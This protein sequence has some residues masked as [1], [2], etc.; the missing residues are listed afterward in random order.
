MQN[1]IE[2]IGNLCTELRPPVV[3]MTDSYGNFHKSEWIMK[4]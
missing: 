4:L 1:S 2:T 3:A